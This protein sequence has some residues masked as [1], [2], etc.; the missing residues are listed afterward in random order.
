MPRLLVV[1]EDLS[2]RIATELRRRGRNTKR[3]AELDLKGTKDPKLLEKLHDLDPDCV[4]ITG[5]NDM[6]ASH[7]EDLKRFGTTVAV[8]HPW[9]RDQPLSEPEW[10]HEIVEKWAHKIEEQPSGSIIR[11]TP[12]GGRRWTVRKRPIPTPVRPTSGS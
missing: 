9:D 4:L 11:Y 7:G 5:D 8:V 2:R 1:D 3:V 12:K 6:P 10:E